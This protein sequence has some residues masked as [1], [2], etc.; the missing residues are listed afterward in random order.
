MIEYINFANKYYDSKKPWI[1]VKEDKDSFNDTTY[2]C[3]YM[4]AN[5]ANLIYPVLPEASEKIRKMLD[6]PEY[7]WDEQLVKGEYKIKNID[8]LY[9]RIEE[10]III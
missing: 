5:M 10:Q 4:I 7:K 8:I 1:Q 3:L 2:N 6:L 9:D